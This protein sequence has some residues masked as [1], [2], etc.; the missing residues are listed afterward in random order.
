[1]TT[2]VEGELRGDGLRV[3]IVVARFNEFVTSKLLNGARAALADN[4]V[5]DKDVTVAWV[6]GSFE[7]PSI[8]RKMSDSGRYD[9]VVCLGAVIRG[10]TDHYEHVAGQ[11]ARGIADAGRE[12]G[13]PV[14]FGVLTTNTVE[15][16]VERAGGQEGAHT[17]TP[18]A[19][20]KTPSSGNSGYNAGV[21]AIQMANLVRALDA[22]P[23]PDRN[24]G[25]GTVL[26]ID[27]TSSAKKPSAC[28][29]LDAA[30]SLLW[31]GSL[32]SDREILDLA[33]GR[34]PS[35]VAIDAPLGFPRGMDCLEDDC[36]CESVWPFNG[37]RAERELIASGIPLYVTTKR[38]F[39]KPM[40]YR[41]MELAKRLEAQGSEVIEVY[42]YAS[43][44]RLFG[45]R[46]PK[47]TTKEG[48]LFLQQRLSRLIPSL[49]SH[50]G[51]LSHDLFDALVAAHTAH[52]HSLGKTE[53]LGL[54][55][56]ARIVVPR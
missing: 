29:L 7:I 5:L 23:R 11:A 27:I 26:G 2:E 41:A 4:G 47:K 15:Q 36:E 3:G 24:D 20:S 37:R 1:M 54:D 52:L 31:L 34:K 8:A 46:P 53:A 13:V 19:P 28:A 38:S 42:P 44:V 21:A 10:E 55:D 30:G 17:E 39:I 51:R 48:L 43:K 18:R 50:E 32:T 14:I 9:A 40:V 45:Q 12:S 56:E 25:A 33:A 6:P 35:L 22:T 49:D 16:A